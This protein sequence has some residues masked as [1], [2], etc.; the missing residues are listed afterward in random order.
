MRLRRQEIAAI[1]QVLGAHLKER[2]AALYLFGSR[3]QDQLKGGDI[4]LLVLASS[5]VVKGLR[6]GKHFLLAELKKELGDQRIDLTLAEPA[7]ARRDPFLS[8][9]LRAAVLLKRWGPVDGGGRK[10][11]QDG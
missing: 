9:A 3:T 8:C 5:A 11:L 2:S 7:K 4:D 6:T 1:I 10:G